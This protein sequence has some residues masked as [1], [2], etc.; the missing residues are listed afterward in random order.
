LTFWH[1]Y[2]DQNQYQDLPLVITCADNDKFVMLSL[3]PGNV[4][5]ALGPTMTWPIW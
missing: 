3:R 2:Y 1:G 5:A 4:N